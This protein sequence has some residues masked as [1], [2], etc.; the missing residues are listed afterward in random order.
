M[1]AENLTADI[2]GVEISWGTAS[3]AY[4]RALRLDKL[5]KYYKLAKF[6]AELFSKDPSTKVGALL[7]AQDSFEILSMGYNGLPR[8]LKDD[9]PERNERP[10]KYY[11]YEHAERNAIFN[12]A[13]KG[14][15]PL[16]GSIAVV[17]MFPCADCARGLIQTGVSAVVSLKPNLTEDRWN[18]H[19]EK[20]R[21][22]LE[23]AGV[24]LILFSPATFN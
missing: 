4:R 21:L 13:R 8:G 10:E 16:E 5:T 15:A 23:E 6:N 7:L 11:Y 2:H 24:T 20:S 17:T 3:Q 9:L 18:A 19:F 12:A 1:S 14:G 22:M